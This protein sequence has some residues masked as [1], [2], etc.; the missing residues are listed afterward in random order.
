MVNFVLTRI[1][2]ALPIVPIVSVIVF[3]LIHA[4]GSDPSRILAGDT[5]SEE[6]IAALR[7]HLALDQPLYRQ[8]AVWFERLLH[9]DFGSSI[10]YQR[11]IIDLVLDRVGATL[12]LA[13]G[14]IFL[15]VAVGVPLGAV[16]AMSLGSR[17]DRSLTAIASVG[18]SLPIFLVAY[19]LVYIFALRLGWLPVQGYVFPAESIAGFL[20]SLILPVMTL[21]LFYI[22]LFARVTRATVSEILRQDY[23]KTAAAKGATPGR[24]LFA[25]ALRVAA[26]PLLTLTGTTFAGLLGGLVVT[27]SLYNI[28]GL[29]RLVSEAILKRDFPIIQG[30]VLITSVFYVSFNLLIDLLCALIDPRGAR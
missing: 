25:H 28:P 19:A 8:F 12:A 27:E 23:I 3:L 26:A 10:F 14:V 20:R 7:H 24:I 4:G 1:L 2:S 15:A 21:G 17:L 11:P 9:G 22:S 18:F 6:A 13:V 29:G 30:L 16:T 5:A